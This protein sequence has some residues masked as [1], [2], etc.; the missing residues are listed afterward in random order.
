MGGR[1]RYT[2]YKSFQYLEPGVDYKEYKLA[3]ELGRV[4]STKIE[5]SK[6]EEE[7]VQ[8]ILEKSIVISLHDHPEVFPENVGDVIE[9]IRSGRIALGYEGL[10]ASYLDAVFDGLENGTGIMRSPDP[11]DWDN[12]IYQIGYRLSDIAMQDFVI[13]AQRVDDILR[14]FNEG[15]VALVLHLEAPPTGTGYDIDRVDVL[16]GLG[17]RCMGIVYSHGNELASGLADR[18]DGGLT[19]LGYE[20]VRRMNKLGMAIDI[21]HAGDRSSLDVIEASKDPVF[22]THAGAR[23]LWPSPRLKPDEVIQALAERGGV[24]GIEA[25][26]HTTITYKNRRHSI[27]SVME[28]FQY[29]EKL[30]GIDYVAFGPDT[31]FGDHVALHKLF[32]KEL[33]IRKAQKPKEMELE[34]PEVEYVD[35]LENPADFPNIVRW[36]VKH[37]Y[38][39]N[40]IKKVIGENVLRVLRRVWR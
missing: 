25:A 19:D 13:K 36:L 15:K 34:F 40:E 29:I 16:H 7:R 14:A 3:K 18:N 23:A 21:S 11:W 6:V 32:A 22:I 30:V 37:G 17:V 38:S 35:G 27:E 2:G 5:L 9:Y 8:E 12:I 39:D 20:V 4:E 24:I 26:P 10:V 31:L 1:K 33:A 28:H